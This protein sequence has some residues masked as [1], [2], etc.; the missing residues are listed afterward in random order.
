MATKKAGAKTKAA[1]KKQAAKKTA[2]MKPAA[3]KAVAA[4][5]TQGKARTVSAKDSK[6]K[7]SSA[8]AIVAHEAGSAAVFKKQAI[9]L[10]KPGKGEVLIRHAAIGVNFIDIYQRTGLYPAPGGY[11]AILGSEG[12]GVIEELGSGT[13]G[14]KVGDRVAYTLPG[15]AYATHRVIA[16]DRLVKLPA[17]V[18]DAVAAA[19]MLKGLTAQ[20]LIHDCYKAKKGDMVL[21]HAAAGGV[22]LILGQW[23]KSIGVTA[24]GTAGGAAKCKLA[25]A[26]GYAH[27]IDYRSQDFVAEV[28]KITKGKGVAAVYDSVGKDT[29]P[30]SLKVLRKFGT[31]V[32]F[33]QSSGPITDFNLADL[34]AN[35][36]LF[37]TRPTLF[38]FIAERSELEK[39][40]KQLFSVIGSGKVKIAVNQTFRLT[41]TAK[42]HRTLES[43]KTTGQTVLI[44]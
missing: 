42:A 24:I 41:E 11:P 34:A 30:G 39:R 23:L 27:V 6:P 44:P 40:A 29:Y 20:Y 12:S 22:G 26:N 31:F 18:S 1:G 32:S 43:R 17:G 2:A 28:N 25:K 37:A 14:L 38:A 3:S 5:A 13:S 4:K 35:G 36:S 10:A 33:G 9:T 16:A 21:V 8:Y 19:A 7:P 15:G